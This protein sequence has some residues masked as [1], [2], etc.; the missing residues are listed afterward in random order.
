MHTEDEVTKGEQPNNAPKTPKSVWRRYLKPVA[1]I[2]LVCTPLAFGTSMVDSMPDGP[3]RKA[4][5]AL[6]WAV[7]FGVLLVFWHRMT[8]KAEAKSGKRIPMAR[9]L[10]WVF[11]GLGC[12]LIVGPFVP[13]II[14][15]VRR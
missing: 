7:T 14:R 12:L 4:G 5:E 15:A 9:W 6:M 3:A 1:I 11:V 2:Y 13:D 8:R 10:F